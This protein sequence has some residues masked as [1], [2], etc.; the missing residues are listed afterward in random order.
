MVIRGDPI[1]T[2]DVDEEND[3]LGDAG[4]AAA[5]QALGPI[6]GRKETFETEREKEGGN[7]DNHQRPAIMNR[8]F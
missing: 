6:G 7:D 4:D 8:G 3:D 2:D 5:N 1:A